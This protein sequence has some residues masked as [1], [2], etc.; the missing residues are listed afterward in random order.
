[1]AE[2][3]ELLSISDFYAEKTILLT[4]GTG[5]LGKVVTE[6]LLRACPLVKKIYLL[7]RTRQGV[8][9]QQRIEELLQ[10]VVFDKVREAAVD[11][12]SKVVPVMGDIAED[13]LGL[14]EEDWEMLQENIEI[15]FHS[16]ATVRFDE[17]LKFRTVM[18]HVSTAYANCDQETIEERIYPPQVDPER[19][20]S[21]IGWMDNNM[22][23]ALTPHLIGNRPNTYTFTKSLAEHVLLQ[24]VEN[25]PIAIFRPSIIGA[26][27][28]EPYEAGK[29]VLRS[30]IGDFNAVADLIPVDY[31]ANMML[32]IA[33]HRVVK[34]HSIIPVYH[35]TT[36]KL[37]GCTWGSICSILTKLYSI[38]PFEKVFRRPNF[39][40]QSTKLMHNYWRYISHRIPALIADMTSF[41]AGQRPVATKSLIYFTSRGWEFSMENYRGLIEDMSPQDREIFYFDVEKLDWDV[42]FN[43]YV[44]G[45]KKFLL[46]EDLANLPLAQSRIRR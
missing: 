21:S 42:Y 13:N 25:F 6:K 24:E 43:R 32:A 38:Y 9:P 12:K 44:I 4:G 1:M 11:F 45:L 22:V 28:K 26:A 17:D 31:C 14:S 27:L 2:A 30:M 46:K 20:S 37:N 15:V 16:A 35:L 40:F 34:R 29:G 33:W 39:A 23:N 7:T 8:K 5:F 41:C 18:V 10:S 36:G 3:K 19:L